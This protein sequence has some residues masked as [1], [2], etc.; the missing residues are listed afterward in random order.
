MVNNKNIIEI[1]NTLKDIGLIVNQD[2][3]DDIF[4]KE[5]NQQIKKIKDELI[6]LNEIMITFAN[7]TDLQKE[8][9]EKTN[10][11]TNQI[12]IDTKI[13]TNNIKKA[14]NYLKLME[15]KKINI[16]SN[17]IIGGLL[18]GGLGSI[19]GIIPAVICCGIGSSIGY[20]I[21]GNIKSTFKKIIN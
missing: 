9:I 5:H 10:N 18:C 19:F 17:T 20:S 8:P 13:T 11:I 1:D 21:G 4:I 15:N 6:Q 7:L 16:I 2:N 12:D 3:I 14:A